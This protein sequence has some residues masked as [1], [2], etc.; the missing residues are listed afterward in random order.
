MCVH[1]HRNTRPAPPM[2]TAPEVLRAH[3]DG[4][5]PVNARA[6]AQG[7]GL[8]VKLVD[9]FDGSGHIHRLETPGKALITINASE[10][11]VRQ[12][13]TLAHEIGHYAL[14]HLERFKD[15]PRDTPEQFS[16]SSSSLVERQANDFAARLLMPENI[17][18]YLITEHDMTRVE[19]LARRFGVSQVAMVYRLKNIGLV[20]ACA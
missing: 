9:H 15:L 18:K 13:F 12:R 1:V 7:M 19:D 4:K 11:H 3:W 8:E 5:L 17:V 14:G 6:I 10:S 20:R 2:L 16:A